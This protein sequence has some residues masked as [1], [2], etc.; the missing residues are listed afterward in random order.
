MGYKLIDVKNGVI[1]LEDFVAQ[2][3]DDELETL[4][5]GGLE[6]MYSPRGVAGNA[7]VF[8]GTSDSL[9]EKGVPPICTNDGP[10][11]IR[12]QAHSTLLPIGIGLA[13]TFD[14]E[15]IEELLYNLSLEM[16]ERKSHTLL[17]PGMNFH[18]NPLCCR[19]F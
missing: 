9:L 6:G 15:L 10:S 11:G 7:G 14:D 19:N 8:G 5:R 4:T 2:L 13:C 17:A 18:R 16:I 3:T 1:S 12:L